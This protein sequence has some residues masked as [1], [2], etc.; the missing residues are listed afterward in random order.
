MPRSRARPTPTLIHNPEWRESWWR[1]DQAWRLI[2]D[3][4]KTLGHNEPPDGLL[5]P[6]KWK[7]K[8][9]FRRV[10]PSFRKDCLGIGL[11]RRVSHA[12]GP[13][14]MCD[15]PWFH[16]AFSFET[17]RNEWTKGLDISWSTDGQVISFDSINREDPLPRIEDDPQAKFDSPQVMDV[18]TQL[19][20]YAWRNLPYALALNRASKIRH[21][22]FPDLFEDD[23]LGVVEDIWSRNPALRA[24]RGFTPILTLTPADDDFF[25]LLGTDAGLAAARLLQLHPN[26]LATKNAEGTVLKVKTI[27]SIRVAGTTLDK[28]WITRWRI[29][30]PHNQ[31]SDPYED[32]S[33]G[34]VI[35]FE[36]IDPP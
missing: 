24:N 21:L 2:N 33:F 11:L 13:Y 6:G 16:V 22:T 27:R 7:W 30:Y 17:S 26:T 12:D 31:D 35:T 29:P 19:A 8:D 28:S 15:Y 18:W 10:S 1:G 34:M 5:P 3:A 23:V 36:D 20:L 25:A 14:E 9:E 4:H 32:F